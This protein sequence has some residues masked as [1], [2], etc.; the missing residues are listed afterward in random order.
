MDPRTIT[1]IQQVTEELLAKLGVEPEVVVEVDESAVVQVSIVS[2]VAEA[3]EPTEATERGIL[4]GRHGET[5]H[6]LQ[7]L[8]GLM[9]NRSRDNWIQVTVDVDGYRKRREEQLIALANRIAEKVLYLREPIAL[10][11]MPATDRRIIH[12][13]LAEHEG[14]VSESTGSGRQRK[15]IVSPA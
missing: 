10:N 11:P 14:V 3:T 7:L 5:L 1:E 8:L 9:V 15:V 4:I 6:A 2:E 13:A 12:M